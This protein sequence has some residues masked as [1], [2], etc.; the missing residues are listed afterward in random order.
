[1]STKKDVQLF[2]KISYESILSVVEWYHSGSY[3]LILVAVIN[4]YSNPSNF[5]V[6]IFLTK[7]T[8][9]LNKDD[10]KLEPY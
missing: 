6:I 8:T 1:M 9:V 2:Y 3:A 10:R 4:H 7:R 5:L